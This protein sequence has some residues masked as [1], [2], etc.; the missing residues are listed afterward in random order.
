MFSLFG[1]LMSHLYLVLVTDFSS[2]LMFS[3][4]NGLS[5][6]LVMD[7]LGEVVLND[8]VSSNASA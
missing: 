3:S 5:G 1:V 8:V 6:V 7:L 4:G 2:D